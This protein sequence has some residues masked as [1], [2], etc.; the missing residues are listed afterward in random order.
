MIL[1]RLFTE[2]FNRGVVVIATSNR[3][4]ED[5]YKNG[6]Q[7]SNFVPFIGVLKSRCNVHCLDSGIDY[8]QKA[9]QK[10]EQKFY[11][12]YV[13]LVNPQTNVLKVVHYSHQEC[14]AN[15]QVERLFKFLSSKENDTVRGRSIIVQG[16][17]V[18]FERACGGVLDCSFNE[19]C[20]R[21]S[22]FRI[23]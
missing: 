10:G 17:N 11:F 1:K 20:D 23:D 3:P 6:L 14:R 13:S 19:L 2:L 7:R 18:T 21:V 12:S 16:R 5:L 9:A 15:E 4:P 8:R 22:Y